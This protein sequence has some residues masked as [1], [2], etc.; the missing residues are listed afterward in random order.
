MA[1]VRLE[2]KRLLLEIV[3]WC[4]EHAK[5]FEEDSG[6]EGVPKNPYYHIKRRKLSWTIESKLKRKSIDV[7]I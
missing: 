5:L 4:F 2:G 3:T 1:Q 7:D 6:L